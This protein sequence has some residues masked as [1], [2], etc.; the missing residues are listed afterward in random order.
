MIHDLKKAT[1]LDI[2]VKN[3]SLSTESSD[4]TKTSVSV[5]KSITKRIYLKYSVGL[6]QENSNVFTLNY[7]LN[8]F[9]SL[10]VTA[11]DIGNGIDFTYSH[12]D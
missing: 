1:G 3:K 10:K 9:L 11:S 5:G 12:S 7:L 4:Y 2:D 6:F 8:K